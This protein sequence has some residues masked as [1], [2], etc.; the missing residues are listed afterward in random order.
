MQEI[1]LFIANNWVS[2]AGTIIGLLYLY[3]EYK[4][5]IWMWAA[6]IIM[7]VFYI[8]I[9]YSTQLYASMGIYC[10]FFLA[11]IYGWIMW[12][13]K[14]KNK[15]TGE[16]I[17]THIPRKFI[18]HV[19]TGILLVGGLIYFILIRYSIDQEYITMGDAL[20]TSINMVALWMA[21][22]KWAE[23]WLL[24]IPANA[25]SSCLLFV[26]GDIMSGCLFSV[27]FIVS[28]FGYYKWKKIARKEHFS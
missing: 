5:K 27:F 8:Y 6:G 15:D 3:F 9:F 21:S 14:G 23:Q 26:Q 12:A 1:I 28:I 20:T 25:I 16:H 24:L 18:L 11:S 17:I 19:I 22:R 2:I 4:A 13:V 7:A 10:Y